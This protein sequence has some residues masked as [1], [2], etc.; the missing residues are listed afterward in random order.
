[1]PA[2]Q[3]PLHHETTQEFFTYL[4]ERGDFEVKETEQYY[5]EE[6]KTFLADRYIKGT[7]PN[8]GFPNA[9]GDQCERCGISLSPEMLIDPVSTLS[10]KPPVKRAY[11][12][13]VSSIG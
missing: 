7:C 6:A 2:P 11:K 5:D 3:I 8:C 4:N 13:M 10:G 1:M 9:F 12:A